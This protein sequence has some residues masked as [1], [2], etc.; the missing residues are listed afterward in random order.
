MTTYRQRKWPSPE[1]D[2]FVE[3]RANVFDTRARS[4]GTILDLEFETT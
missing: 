2:V 4:L 1:Q 3:S